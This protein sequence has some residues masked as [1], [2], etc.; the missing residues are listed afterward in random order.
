MNINGA[1]YIASSHAFKISSWF[2]LRH[3]AC[4]GD[5]LLLFYGLGEDI[6][7]PL[8][9]RKYIKRE[10]RVAGRPPSDPSRWASEVGS[11]GARRLLLRAGFALI[12]AADLQEEQ[13]PPPLPSPRGFSGRMMGRCTA[14][15][16]FSSSSASSLFSFFLF[17]PIL[18]RVISFQK[19]SLNNVSFSLDKL[20]RLKRLYL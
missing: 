19:L 7:L 11:S 5:V 16:R 12:P 9:P 2:E 17:S 10:G 4:E 18:F 14:R 6:I 1:V 20:I 13:D 15:D 8:I 3:C